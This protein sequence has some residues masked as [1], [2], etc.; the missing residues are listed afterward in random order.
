MAASDLKTLASLY[1]MT[2]DHTA[3]T[4]FLC[5]VEYEIESVKGCQIQLNPDFAVHEDNSL[6]NEGREFV[7]VPASYERQME[8]FD[9]LHN[10]LIYYNDWPAHSER[11]SIH[12]HVN[13][14]P[15]T[16][17]K[18]AQFVKLYTLFEPYFFSLVDPSRVNSIYCVPLNYT[19][20]PK[21]Y[22]TNITYQL[23]KWHK[24]TAFNLCPL[25]NYGTIE[26]RHLQGTNDRDTFQRWLSTIKSMYDFSRDNNVDFLRSLQ[27]RE[28]IA[29]L[30]KSVFNKECPLSLDN[31]DDTALDVKLSLIKLTPSAIHSK[32]A[33]LRK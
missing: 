5:G 15:L 29:E 26:F 20:L 31:F 33:R 21:Y 3:S 17:L 19:F 8:M 28:G 14:K 16:M 12:V 1:E 25:P 10:G 32:V 2:P 22:N 9:R 30:F 11:T 7:T 6:R 18:V 27:N 23:Q 13:F 24:Y 4:D